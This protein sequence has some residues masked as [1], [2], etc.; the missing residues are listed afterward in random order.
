MCTT[1]RLY[2]DLVSCVDYTFNPW[3][4]TTSA[5]GATGSGKSTCLRLLYRFYDVTSGSICIDGQDI[6]R[7]TLSSLR[8]A[9]GMVPQD[10]VLFNNSCKYNIRYARGR[11]QAAC[12]LQCALMAGMARRARRMPM[13]TMRRGRR[14]CT[15]PS[16]T[17]FRRLVVFLSVSD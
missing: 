11:L 13:C 5:A 10:V 1:L 3:L 7:V 4:P 8:S 17:S 15:I 6:R 12:K 16:W 14:P 9:I 2:V